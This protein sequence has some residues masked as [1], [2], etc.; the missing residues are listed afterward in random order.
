MAVAVPVAVYLLSLWALYIRA[1]D[2]PIRRF[3]VPMVASLLVAAP[4]TGYPVLLVGLLLIVLVVVKEI[5]RVRS[6][7]ETL[8]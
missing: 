7:R 5:T 1:G 4:F 6:D 3:G 2:P 8:T